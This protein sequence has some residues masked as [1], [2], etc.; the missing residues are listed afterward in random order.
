MSIAT[1]TDQ[2]QNTEMRPQG[3]IIA[4]VLLFVVLYIVGIA[5]GIAE[6]SQGESDSRSE[7]GDGIRS[8]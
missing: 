2:E 3:A 8:A 4:S 6:T 1:T 5:L 7:P